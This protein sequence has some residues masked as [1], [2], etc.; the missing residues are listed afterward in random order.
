MIPPNLQHT[1][2]V[3]LCRGYYFPLRKRAL[4]VTSYHAWQTTF[5]EALEMKIQATLPGFFR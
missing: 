1:N 4:L 2:L 3:G 5:L